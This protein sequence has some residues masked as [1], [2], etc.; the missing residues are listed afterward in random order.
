M[1]MLRFMPDAE[2]FLRTIVEDFTDDVMVHW[3][4]DCWHLHVGDQVF[5][6]ETVRAAALRAIVTLYSRRAQARLN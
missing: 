4:D 6:G 5:E 1:A 2:F 3:N